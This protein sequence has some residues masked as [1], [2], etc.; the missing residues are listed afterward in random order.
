VTQLGKNMGKEIK[1]KSRK[2]FIC[3]DPWGRGDDRVGKIFIRIFTNGDLPMNP[4]MLGEC[5]V[6]G[7]VFTRDQSREHSEA[8]CELS[9]EQPFS[10]A[11]RHN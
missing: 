2:A 7:G 8:R 9:S 3:F 1:Q 6:C 5:V 4:M 11:S 10:A